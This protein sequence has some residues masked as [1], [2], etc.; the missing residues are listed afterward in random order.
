M[1][2]VSTE[3]DTPTEKRARHAERIRL[4]KI[5]VMVFAGLVAFQLMLWGLDYTGVISLSAV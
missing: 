3:Q 2:T 5:S 4:M 1:E